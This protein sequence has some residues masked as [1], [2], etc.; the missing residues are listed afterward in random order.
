MQ[1]YHFPNKQIENHYVDG[2][3]EVTF[4]DGTVRWILDGT[5]ETTFGDG[6]RRT[7]YTADVTQQQIMMQG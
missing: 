5:V 3:K 4:P 7:D 6:T 2:R 1:T